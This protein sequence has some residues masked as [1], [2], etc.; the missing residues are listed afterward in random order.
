VS[1]RPTLPLRCRRFRARHADFVAGTLPRDEAA[2]ADAHREGCRSCADHDARLRRALMM[3]AALPAVDVSPD[4]ASRLLRRLA[5]E[6]PGLRL[7]PPDA[8]PVGPVA[9][10]P[11]RLAAH[12]TAVAQSPR[13][14]RAGT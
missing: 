1:A 8:S 10:G 7:L 11:R 4:F 2:W 5:A 12:G 14:G 9:A 13:P 3:L 6:R